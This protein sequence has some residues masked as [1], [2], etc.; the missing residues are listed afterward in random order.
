MADKRISQL[1]ERVTLATNDVFPIVA[2]GATTTNKVTLQTIDDYMQTNLDFG[3]T[4]VAI[5]VPTGLS[6][7]GTPITSTGTF[8]ITFTAGYSIPTTAKQTQWDE[9]YTNRIT[10]ATAPL[11]IASNVIS[12]TQAGSTTNGFLSSTD[13]NTF[14]NKQ[15]TITTGNLTE[16]T[17][18]VLTITGGTGSV[19]GSGTSIEVKQAS[20]SQDGFLD[21]ADWTTF[22]GKQNALSGTGIVK[23]T[24]GTISY[25]TDNT[26]NWDSAY[27]DKINSASVTGT[28]TKT[29]T[30]NQQDGG[31]ITTTWTDLDTGTVTSVGVSMPSAFSVANS[32]ITSSGTIAITG[33]GTISQYIDGTG[34]LRTFPSI[35]SQATNLV[36]EVYNNSGATMTKGTVVY[37]NGGQGNLPTIAKALAT[38]DS[39]SAQTYGVVQN[40]IGN[41]SNGY[42]VVVGDLIDMDTQAFVIG[43]QLYLSSSTAGEYTS[44]KQ[45][46]PNHLVYVG[47]V[48]RSHPTQGI[49]AVKIQNGYE[50]DEIH[51]V[52][53]QNPNN[54]DILQYKTATGLWTKTAGTTSNIAEGTNLYYTDARS[55]AAISESVTGLDY[56]SSTGVLSTTTGYAIPTTASQTNWDAAYNDKIN[57]AAVTG[58]TTKTLTLTQQD[59]GTI[60]ASWT[61]IN[62]DAVSSVFGRTGAVVATSGDYNTDQV[63][64]GSSNL[65]FTNAR[66][67]SSITLTTT[68]T[69]GAATYNSTTGVLNIPSYVGGVT[70][71]NTLTGAVV[72][73]TS[74]IAEGT[75]LYYTDTRAR[76]AISLTTTGT[77][78]AAT[79]SGGVLNIPNYSTDLSGYVPYT[80]ATGAVNLGNNSL[81][82]RGITVSKNAGVSTITFPAG[83]NDPAFISHTESTE[84][85]GI[86]R[87]SVGDDNDTIDYFAF[88][89]LNNADAFR[90]NSNGT[91]QTGVW[92]GTA[93]ADT[94][95]SSAATWNG[96]QNAITLTT[97][98]TSGAATF[99]GTTLNIPNYSSPD[100]SGYVPFTGATQ[101]VNIGGQSFT[102]GRGYFNFAESLPATSGT[103]QLSTLRIGST[104]SG[105]SAV[106]DFGV[107]PGALAWIQST[108]RTDLSATTPLFLNPNG[109]N[110]SINSRTSLGFALGVNGTAN[111]SSTL[112]VGGVINASDNLRF[113]NASSWGISWLSADFT[114]AVV[115]RIFDN[116][117]LYIWT[118]DQTN[119]ASTSN[120]ANSEWRWRHSVSNTG[121]GGSN[122]MYLSNN[123]LTVTGTI[124]GSNLSGTNTG[125]QDLSGYL[126]LA[127]SQ[128]ITGEKSIDNNLMFANSGTSKRGIQGV[129]GTNDYWFVG[130]GAT[131][132][133]AG[134]MEIATGDDGQTT[135][136][137]EPIYVRQYGPGSPLTGTLFRSATLLDEN[138][139]TTFPGTLSVTGNIT[140]SGNIGAGNSSPQARIDCGPSYPTSGVKLL[141]YN[142]DNSGP[143]AGT[144]VGFYMD[145]FSLSNNATFVFPTATST[146]GTFIIASKD[147]SGTSLV[148]RVRFRG[149]GNVGIDINPAYKLD[150]NGAINTND[151]VRT[152]N[153]RI[154]NTMV[155]SGSGAEIGNSVGV[156][157]TESYGVVWN[158]GNSMTWHHQIINGSSLVGLNAGGTNFGSGNIYAT[159]DVVAFYSDMRLKHK[160]SNIENA[161]D[162]VLKLNGFYYVNN[163]VAKA[164]GYT[165]ES[166]QIGVSAQEVE[167]VLPEIVKLAP[168]DIGCGENGAKVSK[169]GENYKTISYERLTPLLIEAIK[170]QQKQI[171]ELKNLINAFTK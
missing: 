99:N 51:D 71:V 137:S 90:I 101:N 19:I 102:A 150:V 91:I 53:A 164:N 168:F 56:N 30:L 35:I 82:A 42:I 83:T 1:V 43:T 98:G 16:A 152:G 135:G 6:V 17:S 64:E 66:S 13:W 36:R 110:V 109:G 143:L 153:I 108:D 106:M 47:I 28:T 154:S 116:A 38:G 23:S 166:V 59:G 87:F 78:G 34:A 73:T 165:D 159:G 133:N 130:G 39:T 131:A 74:N 12:I 124:T 85:V 103:T 145:R 136:T 10:S 121:T 139:N 147:T 88:G 123:N 18:S 8:V 125:D 3:V 5:S 80:G 96:K 160:I 112:G 149:N 169:S 54:N 70:S 67:R 45:Y 69:S 141:V 20:G 162:K 81:S 144:K 49:I 127:G 58:T 7:T 79:Y 41:M 52:S 126:T 157:M 111:I 105:Q 155:L 15:S 97:T 63:T 65:Y 122:S 156:R 161:L 33:A 25:L 89:N 117:Q 100:L 86:M 167:S 31:T 24:G 170:E 115:S 142:D 113:T 134:F 61:D 29:L 163:E 138:G 27:N 129:C 11:G 50:M 146:E 4:S 32:P 26:S 76:A 92:Q 55:R 40:S 22:N 104:I 37:I 95:I 119:F 84:N 21:S 57:S 118:D 120:A 93:I 48:T 140:T 72:L 9:A 68:G 2:S 107:A 114:G 158:C 77:S 60:T 148:E 46:A 14:N 128:T 44:T 75:N 171:D 94:Y 62:T 151:I 132:T